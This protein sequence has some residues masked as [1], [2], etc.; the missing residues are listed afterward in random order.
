MQIFRVL[1]RIDQISSLH[2]CIA[3]IVYIYGWSY[4]LKC[5]Y[6]TYPN[7]NTFI[8]ISGIIYSSSS[9]TVYNV[10]RRS[11]AIFTSNIIYS[12]VHI[13]SLLLLPVTNFSVCMREII[14]TIIS[15]FFFFI[16]T[17]LPLINIPSNSFTFIMT[18]S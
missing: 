13:V 16:Y 8:V 2:I 4:T 7:M 12:F 14:C 15:N 10:I 17:P 11:I 1:I 9:K 5:M 18:D 6:S 3:C